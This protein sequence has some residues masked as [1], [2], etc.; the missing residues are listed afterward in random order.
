MNKVLETMKKIGLENHVKPEHIS[1]S[2]RIH[3][4]NKTNTFPDP[5]I[6]KL[7]ARQ[8]KDL[9]VGN[10]SKLRDDTTL[11]PRQF[12]NEDLTPLRSKLLTYIKT[13]VPA[14]IS[15]SVHTREGRILCKKTEDETKWIYIESV[16]DLQKL[17]VNISNDLLKEL[18]IDNCVINVINA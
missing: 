15:K 5:I 17:N 10:S 9:I 4:K 2:H 11:N 13:K 12:I 14:V 6:V 16:R 18:D 8:T 3:R 7:L 1:T